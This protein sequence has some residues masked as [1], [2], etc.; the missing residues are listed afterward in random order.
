[1][2]RRCRD[3]GSQENPMGACGLTSLDLEH[4]CCRR[5]GSAKR[6]IHLYNCF[7]MFWV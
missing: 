7:G 1:M 6:C 2:C 5:G 3:H 4:C